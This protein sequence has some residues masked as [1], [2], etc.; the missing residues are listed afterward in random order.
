ME[1]EMKLERGIVS[2]GMLTMALIATL[3]SG[4][5]NQSY[6]N[7]VNFKTE[8]KE[9]QKV[10]GFNEALALQRVFRKIAET[11]M[12][13]TVNI[14]VE[15]EV[16]VQNPFGQNPFF[17]DPFFRRFF[18]MPEMDE[19]QKRKMQAQGSGVIVSA[20]GYIFSNHH[21]VKNATKITVLL[22][23]NREF[24]AKLV[25]ADPE[26]DVA[27]LKIEG[28]DFPYAAIGDS[29]QVQ[30]GDWA[31][32]IGNPFGLA[33]TFTVGF[34]SAMGRPGMNSGFQ[35]FIQSDTAVNPG[36]SGGPLVNIQGQVIGIN[37]A[38]QSQSGGYQGISFAVPIN[39]VLTVAR[40]IIDKGTVERGFLGIYPDNLDETTR[41][42]FK[43]SSKE[44]VIISRI[45]EN[46]PA[47]KAGLQQGDIIT[48]I[49]GKD[50]NDPA[51]LQ[52]MV[53]SLEP[54]SKITIEY[55]RN[56]S[57]K[58][59]TVVLARRGEKVAEGNDRI[60]D[61]D[62]QGPDSGNFEFKG[63]TFRNPSS[64]ELQQNGAQYGVIV[65]DIS[66]K[67]I[68]AGTLRPGEIIVSINNTRIKNMADLKLFADSNNSTRAFTLAII[69][70]GYLYYRGVEK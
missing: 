29:D 7:T 27:I 66:S 47:E 2:S 53:G 4:S 28:K 15:S 44:G 59:V 35:S 6:S 63:A 20:D 57:R 5:C 12:P 43:L 48:K 68:F 33:G 62:Q 18:E 69:N 56:N 40:Q 32:A 26:T 22:A 37:T 41:K 58:E 34:V 30:V 52:R 25:G 38:I 42:H 61:K 60:P 31:I 13:A 46:S 45:V 19:E 14:Y 70:R 16:E 54:G 64:Q 51:A 21:V 36:N 1:E 67:S 65:T 23:D 11:V 17:N 8:N 49:N 10:E 3:V 55:L 24:K 9:V 50:I 39:T